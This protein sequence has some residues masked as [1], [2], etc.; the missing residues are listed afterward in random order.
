MIKFFSSQVKPSTAIHLAYRADIDGLRGLQILALIGFH[1]FS[2]IVPGGYVGVD[3]F[4]VISGFLISSIIFKS[5]Q[6][7]SFDFKDFYV[8]RTKRIFPSLIVILIA[9]FTI[10]WFV[11]LPDEFMQLGKHIAGG[12]IFIDNFLFWRESGY[13]D[14]DVELKPLLHLWS[15]GIEEQFYLFWPITLLFFW[16][17]KINLLY[18][19]IAVCIFSLGLSS[20]LAII[21]RSQALDFYLPITR[22]WGII[23]G[24]I[25][26]NLT[27]L[28]SSQ[29]P[30]TPKAAHN[31]YINKN[32]QRI[33]SPELINNFYSLLGFSL[34]L[35]S[36]FFFNRDVFYPGYAALTPVIGAVL[37]IA[38]GSSGI[39][40][41][42]VLSNPLMIWLGLISYPLYLWHW[43]LLSFSRIIESGE[44]EV[45][46]RFGAVILAIFLSWLTFRFIENPIRFN[47]NTKIVIIG[48]ISSLSLIGLIGFYTYT[49]QGFPNRFI[50]STPTL[51]SFEFPYREK[52]NLITKN[53]Y[54]DDWCHL[55]EGSAADQVL[56][57]GDS[58][59]NAFS[60]VLSTLRKKYDFTFTQIG[61]GE[62]PMLLDFG[63]KKC[64]EIATDALNYAKQNSSIK[65][66][67]IAARWIT[68]KNGFSRDGI[69]NNQFD[70]ELALNKTI[71]AYENLGIKVTLILTVPTSN[72]PRSCVSRPFQSS[73][74]NIEHC[75]TP[76]QLVIRSDGDY[77]NFIYKLRDESYHNVTLFDPWIYLCNKDG[78]R[79]TAGSKIL[80]SDERHLSIYGGEYIAN[81][82]EEQLRQMIYP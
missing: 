13:F 33:F 7:G 32:L 42:I 27:I 54:E 22:L 51:V 23:F 14:R 49:N 62:C 75:Y 8:R 67:I 25:L 37:M 45:E 63:Y 6:K 31:L 64:Q 35:H 59:S 24:A 70:Y 74:K 12:A 10:G 71:Q 21:H 44:P 38:A 81:H 68:Y 50:S 61:R 26:A 58:H 66:V 17:R 47:K 79:I 9:A 52:C 48:L 15:L 1:G 72:N 55:S 57:I 76:I 43:M 41:R 53:S 18:I 82:A 29:T 28:N 20:F 73:N 11:L 77:R 34:I 39:V 40:N 5:L 30:I 4:F 56:L 2:T 60:S 65:S 3:I 36:V 78:C 80:Y 69:K 46:V 16:K 19:T